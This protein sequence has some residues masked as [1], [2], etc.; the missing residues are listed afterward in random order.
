MQIIKWKPSGHVGLAIISYVSW[1]TY[2][3]GYCKILEL[4]LPLGPGSSVGRTYRLVS[5][6]T[7]ASGMREPLKKTELFFLFLARFCTL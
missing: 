5:F 1:K 2:P 6:I 7:L 4:N 3:E